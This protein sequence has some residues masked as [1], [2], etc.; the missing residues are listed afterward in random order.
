MLLSVTA[1][2]CLLHPVARAA[3]LRLRWGHG[4]AIVLVIA[5]PWFFLM[6]HKFGTQFIDQ[7]VLYNNLSLFGRPLYRTNRY[8]LF[9]GRV[10]MTAFLPWSPIVLARIADIVHTRRP[11]RDVPFGEFVL[12]A[13][14]TPTS[15]RPLPRCACSPPTPGS[16]RGRVLQGTGGCDGHWC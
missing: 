2:L 13:S 9:Y 15:S 14:S 1:L 3:T 5:A 8:P 6:W 4:I 7:Y 16:R 12:G 10:F 11:L